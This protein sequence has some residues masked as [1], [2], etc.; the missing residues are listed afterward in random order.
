MWNR[1][2]GNKL[3]QAYSSGIHYRPRLYSVFIDPTSHESPT[4]WGSSS[5]FLPSCYLF[6]FLSIP[7]LTGPDVPLDLDILFWGGNFASYLTFSIFPRPSFRLNCCSLFCN[8]VIRLP[9]RFIVTFLYRSLVHKVINVLRLILTLWERRQRLRSC[10][11][12]TEFII[13]PV[14]CRSDV[15]IMGY[16]IMFCRVKSQLSPLLLWFPSHVLNCFCLFFPHSPLCCC[17]AFFF[18][19][20][21]PRALH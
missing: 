4:H 21:R 15:M 18:L 11:S 20:I 5:S 1:S 10:A 2:N 14:F 13:A 17:G 7:S 3:K 8:Y 12:M 9:L 19:I 6:I 16:C